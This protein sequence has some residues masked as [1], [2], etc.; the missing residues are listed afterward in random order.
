MTE[1]ALS[2]PPIARTIPEHI[3]QTLA[4]AWPVVVSRASILIMVSVDVAMS[5]HAGQ[6]Q[7][8]YVSIAMAIQ[9]LFLMVGVGALF[10]TAVLV[11]QSHGAGE[12]KA[13]GGIWRLAIL[14]AAG[15]GVI[16]GL[17]C[18]GGA[19]FLLAIGHDADLA[20][21][22]GRVLNQFSWGMVP[23]MMSVV[24]SMFLEAIGRPRPGM[25]VMVAANFVNIGLNWLFIYGNWG[26]PEMG[27]EGAILATTIVRWLIFAAL[28]AYVFTMPG[29]AACGIRGG[30]RAAWSVGKKLRRIGYPMG[31]AQGIEASAFSGLIMMAGYFG[32]A[33]LGGYQ[34][35]QNLIA[36]AFMCAIGIGVA[37]TVRVGNAIG[38][39]DQAGVA[40]AGWTGVGI[41]L[42]AMAL[43]AL[44]FETLPGTLVRIYTSDPAVIDVSITLV[45]IAG[46]VLVFDGAQ[47]VLM[48]ALRGTG[49]V[50]V[51]V[52]IQFLA[53]GLIALPVAAYLAFEVKLGAPGLMAGMCAGVISASLLLGWR[54]R[55]VSQ[56]VVRRL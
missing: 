47:G 7:L 26:A 45:M 51:P 43:I 6:L 21:G 46:L 14:H 35:A 34:I 49:D 3:R 17:L 18:L 23:M 54:F 1:P 11:A 22:G 53:F 31:F 19:W 36:L 12:H 4:L 44:L 29:S 2:F 8:A 15:I 25:I 32:A 56:R 52:C 42:I 9:V 37:T 10:G 39:N 5:G 33:T 30:R 55:I 28:L 27:G 38:R 40:R 20:R 16:S 48:S 41:V 13:C 50:W 24:T